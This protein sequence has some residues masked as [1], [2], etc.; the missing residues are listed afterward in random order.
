MYAGQ[1]H[2]KCAEYSVEIMFVR[3]RK[4]S[5]NKTVEK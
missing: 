4:N 1:V 2:P 3:T 5:T